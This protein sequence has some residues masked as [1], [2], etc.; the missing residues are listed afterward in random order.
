VSA[1]GAESAVSCGGSG[2]ARRL[3]IQAEHAAWR[4]AQALE[5][6]PSLAC[7]GAGGRRLHTASAA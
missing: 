5:Q 6:A 2:R 1:A 7:A 3:L 4:T